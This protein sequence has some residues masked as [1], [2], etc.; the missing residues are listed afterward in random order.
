MLMRLLA[1]LTLAVAMTGVAAAEDLALSGTPA[2]RTSR[3]RSA[4]LRTN[5]S[6][7]LPLAVSVRSRYWRNDR[8]VAVDAV[9]LLGRLRLGTPAATPAGARRGS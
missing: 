1:G 7:P 2:V 6:A 4:L 9:T 5:H 8:W 3:R